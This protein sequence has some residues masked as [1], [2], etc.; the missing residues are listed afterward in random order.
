[1]EPIDKRSE[2]K[3]VFEV[4]AIEV[5]MGNFRCEICGI[6]VTESKRVLVI[7]KNEATEYHNKLYRKYSVIEKI[8]NC[9]VPK[10][11]WMHT[12]ND[13]YVFLAGLNYLDLLLK[14]E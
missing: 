9:P 5:V 1:M 14:M 3:R 4:S 10:D 2:E 12:T 7:P 6:Q 11:V 13:P 8:C